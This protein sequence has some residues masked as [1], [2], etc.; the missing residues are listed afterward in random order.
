MSSLSRIKLCK[1][2]SDIAYLI[3]YQ[4]KKLSYILYKIPDSSKYIEFE[5]PKATKGVRKISAPIPELKLAQ[6]RLARVLQ[7][8]LVEIEGKQISRKDCI[9]SHGFKRNL[10]ISTNGARH[11]DRKWI[12]NFDLKDFF[13]SI[14][15]GRVRGFFIKNKHFLLDEKAAT[16][17]A[18]LACNNSILPQGAPTSPVISNLIA[19]H[20][21]I[22]LSKVATKN[23]CTY[24]RY[25]D[26]ITFSTNKSVFPKYIAIDRENGTS[27]GDWRL[28][29][30]ILSEVKRSGFEVNP[31]KTRMLFKRSRQDVTGLV[32]N[33]KVNVKREYYKQ[34]R[35]Q[36]H[37]FIKDDICFKPVTIGGAESKAAVSG[38][39][40]QGMLSH[41]FWVKGAEYNYRRF[42]KLEG[43]KEPAFYRDYRRFLDYT[44]FVASPQPVV[45]CEGVTDNIYVQCAIKRSTV[46]RPKLQDAG[47]PSGLAIRLFQYAKI[48]SELRVP[49]SVQHLNGG[50]GDLKGLIH[51]YK[52]RTGNL[53]HKGFVSPVILLVDND[54][55]SRD[56]L[57]GAV[58]TA[59]GSKVTVDGTARFYHVTKNLY[60]I[61]T[62]K[63]AGG[64][65][66]MIEDFLPKPVVSQVLGGKTFNPDEK[67]FDRN[68]HYG[69]RILAEK[70]SKNQE[71]IDFNSFSEILNILED[72]LNHFSAFPR[73]QG[74][75]KL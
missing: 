65:D 9:V 29:K 71:N 35:A 20:L 33:E 60:V 54:Q 42:S 43:P 68:K 15:F 73:T 45:I 58:K 48:D 39:A 40:L 18:Q 62:P 31:D 70:V 66:S 21:D 36:V 67:T 32:V 34:V 27:S 28:S 46:A 64:K 2:I 17:F 3:G 26:D 1:N 56:G 6:S 24:T 61:P 74:R 19:N 53:S 44:S 50:T 49:S 22:R 51:K 16:I 47:S 41:I 11:V 14:N 57:W 25:A 13:P 75:V 55:G 72:V 59:S 12:L 38:A 52:S 63:L 8:C 37:S 7:D 4:P 10:S 5:I 30:K 69:K 23:R